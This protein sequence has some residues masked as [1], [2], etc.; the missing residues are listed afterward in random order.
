MLPL[1]EII[2][3]MPTSKDIATDSPTS[4]PVDELALFGETLRDR[5]RR[6]VQTRLDKRLRG[7]IDAADVVQDGFVEAIEKLQTGRPEPKLRIVLWLIIRER[8]QKLHRNHLKTAR[9]DATRDVSMSQCPTLDASGAVP[10]NQFIDRTASPSK[11]L[12]KAEQANRLRIAMEKLGPQDRQ[13]LWLRHFD[14]LQNSEVACKLQIQEA[15]AAKRYI[16]AMK[17]L[18]QVLSDLTAD[19]KGP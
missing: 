9:R 10:T 3:V 7:R 6:I 15:A 8:L 18:K 5:L 12:L 13:V 16:R 11:S 19:P 1:K 4:T 2:V 17:R 14:E